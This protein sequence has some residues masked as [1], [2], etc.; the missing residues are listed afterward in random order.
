MKAKLIRKFKLTPDV[1]ELI[2]EFDW[3]LSSLAWQFITFILPSWLRRAYSIAF[4]NDS[5]FEFIIKRLEDGRWWSKEICD[6][7]LWTSL[8]FIWPVWHFVLKETPTNKLFIGTG[9]WFAPLYFQIKKALELWLKSNLHF[10]FWVRHLEDIF[11]E[12]ELEKIKN[13]NSNF[14]YN[15]YLSREESQKYMKWYVTDFLNKENVANFEEFYICG[16]PA[17]VEDSR[18]KLLELGILEDKIYF[19]KY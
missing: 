11:Y 13:E 3:N 18:K 17:M 10:I 1:Y 2:F 14:D 16:S 9:T 7:E 5:K 6:L 12:S 4:Q 15:L 19:E 8:D